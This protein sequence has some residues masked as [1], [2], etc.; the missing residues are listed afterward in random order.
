[1]PYNKQEYDQYEFTKESE[2]LQK[3]KENN[4]WLQPLGALGCRSLLSFLLM[5]D[6]LDSEI[7]TINLGLKKKDTLLD[8]FLKDQ[9]KLLRPL[10][11][12]L[13]FKVWQ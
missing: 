12:K 11:M 13:A 1:M 9:S 6:N 3:L 4:N 10:P 5:S 2:A 7:D 8:H